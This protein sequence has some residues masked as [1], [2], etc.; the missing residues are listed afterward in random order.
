M[1]AIMSKNNDLIWMDAVLQFDQ[2]YQSTV[3][4]HA[5]ETGVNI[6]DHVIETNDK[7][8]VRGV[9]TNADFNLDRPKVRFGSLSDEELDEEIRYKAF[10]NFNPVYDS[11]TITMGPPAL[12][13][14]LPASITQ[15]LGSNTP[16]VTLTPR[17]MIFPATQVATTL[18]T[19]HKSRDLVKII[20]YRPDNSYVVHENLIMTSLSDNIDPDSGDAMYPDMTFERVR[21]ADVST[22]K[23]PQELMKNKVAKKKAKGKVST[24][25]SAKTDG[26][27]TAQQQENETLTAKEKAQS[28]A[29][30][31]VKRGS[32]Q[33]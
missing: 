17:E 9:V 26:F 22:T 24:K 7:F 13:G 29:E 16:T 5:V 33:K 32:A 15:F 19:M 6:S 2:Q 4:S 28:D 25:D 14:L 1:L 18:K 10:S 12:A 31:A 21:Y 27:I 20:E 11:P 30:A 3:T 8:R 23:I